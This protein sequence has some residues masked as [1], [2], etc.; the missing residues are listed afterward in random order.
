M[1]AR[2]FEVKL[3]VSNKQPSLNRSK[4]NDIASTVRKKLRA[5][6]PFRGKSANLSLSS[7]KCYTYNSLCTIHHASGTQAVTAPG[8]A[9]GHLTP[10]TLRSGR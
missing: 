9:G 8:L 2:L 10:S 7:H 5:A 1:S 3:K 4:G 6:K